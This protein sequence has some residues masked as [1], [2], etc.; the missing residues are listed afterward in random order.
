MGEEPEKFFWGAY[1]RGISKAA[2]LRGLVKLSRW[3][4]RAK[5]ALNNTLLP[6]LTGLLE[7]GKIDPKDALAL[8]RL[9]NPVEYYYASTKEYAEALHQKAGPDPV[10]VE[11]LI[12]QFHDDNPEMGVGGTVETLQ[13]LAEEALGPSSELTKFLANAHKRYEEVR[14][15]KNERSNY[16]SDSD[17]RIRQRAEDRDDIE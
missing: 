11:E 15:T 17:L 1:G 7:N 10:V 13:S 9:A 12:N 16:R 6:Y 2:G 4:D 3:D 14:D 5:I 8:N